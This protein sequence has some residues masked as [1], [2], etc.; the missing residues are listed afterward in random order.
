MPEQAT[1]SA[2]YAAYPTIQRIIVTYPIGMR[3]C[4]ARAGAS[5]RPF[6]PHTSERRASGSRW[7]T[8]RQQIVHLGRSQA[9]HGIGRTIVELDLAVILQ[10]GSARKDGVVSEAAGHLIGRLGGKQRFS[11]QPDDMRR[12]FEI[13]QHQ[14]YRIAFTP[15]GLP[16]VL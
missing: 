3:A 14:T 15:G 4:S 6:A 2:L 11:V 7:Q 8:E 16:A 1:P 5:I 12:V 10:N 13:E 9:H